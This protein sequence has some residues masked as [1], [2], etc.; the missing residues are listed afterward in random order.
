M[1][2][3]SRKERRNFSQVIIRRRVAQFPD[4]SWETHLEPHYYHKKSPFRK[5]NPRR[6][7]QKTCQ[8]LRGSGWLNEY[9]EEINEL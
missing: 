7:S 8:E 3:R 4:N 6:L 2:Q 9:Y 1:N 5:P